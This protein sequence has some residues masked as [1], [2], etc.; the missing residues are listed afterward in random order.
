MPEHMPAPLRPI[1]AQSAFDASALVAA[2]QAR[3]HAFA[4]FRAFSCIAHAPAPGYGPL[5]GVTLAVKGNIAVAG[6]PHTEGSAAFRDRVAR[7]DAFAVARLRQVG[8]V[9]IGMATL[10]E[11]AMYAPDNAAEPMGLNPW[12]VTRTAGGSSTGCGVAV[13]L[14]LAALGLGTDSG[15]SVR[16]PALHCGVVGFKP[17]L[18]AWDY[19]GATQPAP[20]LDTLGLIGRRVDCV[21]RGAAVL[22]TTMGV[23]GTRLLV[24]AGLVAQACD[25]AT[26]SLFAAA[27]ACLREAGFAIVDDEIPL[28]R[29]AD[30]ACG[31]V[32]LAE[33]GAWL[34]HLPPDAP[35]GARLKARRL[36]ARALDRAAVVE[37]R[38]VMARFAEALGASLREARATAVVTPGWPFAAP[39][40]EAE[41]ID[42]DGTTI[43]LDPARSLFVRT[44]NAAA[45]PAIILPAGLYRADGVPFGLHLLGAPGEDGALL[46][47]AAAVEAALPPA[48]VP[49]VALSPP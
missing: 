17:S 37:A 42:L 48:P 31:I 29:E 2:T 49:P 7:E 25:A 24:P 38:G 12:D 16:N 13:A 34:D 8:A 46:A 14:G 44:A 45:A 22:G 27:L 33:G 3:A 19:T 32:S 26:R 4:R 30:A 39:R 23:A 10:S 40:I 36:A 18:G 41:T 6:M 47:L 15:G 11:L 20:S 1:A 9:P 35:I 43:P 5:A 21:A 28:W